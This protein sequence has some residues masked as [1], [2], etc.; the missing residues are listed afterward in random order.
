LAKLIFHSFDKTIDSFVFNAQYYIIQYKFERI[1][2]PPSNLPGT[3]DAWDKVN[4]KGS[5]ANEV[6]H[7]IQ[8]YYN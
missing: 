7:R 5:Y 6:K 2:N 8:V 4:L 3:G 1:S